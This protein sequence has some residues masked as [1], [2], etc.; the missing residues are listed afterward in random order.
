MRLKIIVVRRHCGRDKG[1]AERYCA[2]LCKALRALGHEV[3]LV[4]ES[5]EKELLEYVRFTRIK[6]VSFGSAAKNWSFHARVQKKIREIPH[7]VSIALSR[8]YPVDVYRLTERLH[9]HIIAPNH[10][11][12]ILKLWARLSLRHRVLFALERGVLSARGSKAIIAI[13]ELDKRLI[14][15]YYGVSSDKIHVVYNGVDT[16]FFN[17][18][19]R[20]RRDEL[21]STLG[22]RPEVTCYLFPAMEFHK[23][24]LGNLLIALSDLQFPW[25]LLVVGGGKTKSYV[26]QAAL[27]GIGD[28]V[29]FVGKR[30]DINVFYGAADLMVFPAGYEPF[31]NV[32]LEALACGLPVLTTKEVGGSE[33]VRPYETGYVID[34]GSDIEA[35]RHALKDYEQRRPLW[36][37]MSRAAAESVK[38][39]TVE[40]NARLVEEVL[41]RVAR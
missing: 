41:F 28:R 32:H 26:K 10:T 12:I 3:I 19:V 1:G 31:G 2:D 39:F 40:K 9:A 27:L 36:R 8:T 5:C 11:P 16:R 29:R 30:A 33:V 35:L 17:D 15:K 6:P 13:S 20:L 7:E 25:N 21:R 18:R 23:K 37:A 22:I 38:S 24:G 4:G 34:K 14:Q